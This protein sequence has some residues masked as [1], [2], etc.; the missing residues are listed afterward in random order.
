MYRAPRPP[1][2]A[3]AL[4]RSESVTDLAGLKTVLKPCC[5]GPRGNFKILRRLRRAVRHRMVSGPWRPRSP[6]TSSEN[7]PSFTSVW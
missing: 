4:E 7:D 6:E 1:Q 3:R 2:S 5:A